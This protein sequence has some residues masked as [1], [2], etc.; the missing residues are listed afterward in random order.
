MAFPDIR[1]NFIAGPIEVTV[2][3]SSQTLAEL[4]VTLDEAT[5]RITLISQNMEQ[6]SWAYDTPAIDGTNKL[7]GLGLIE[8]DIDNNSGSK[9]EF[10]ATGSIVM[11]VVQEG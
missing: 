1:F 8:I 6:I 7:P 4:G 9:L 2:S 10:I 5:K 3:T 11:S